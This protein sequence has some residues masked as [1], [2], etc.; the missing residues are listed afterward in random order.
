M[1]AIDNETLTEFIASIIISAS[2]KLSI[3]PVDIDGLGVRNIHTY[4]AEIAETIKSAGCNAEA[5]VAIFQIVM[6]QHGRTRLI[7]GLKVRREIIKSEPGLSA[8][9]FFEKHTCATTDEHKTGRVCTLKMD[10]SFPDICSVIFV[11]GMSSDPAESIYERLVVKL[12]FASINMAPEVQKVN[13]DATRAAWDSWG[14]TSGKKMSLDGS[15]IGFDEEIYESQRSDRIPLM[16]TGAN[17]AATSGS[18]GY[19]K[20]DIIAWINGLKSTSTVV[21]AAKVSTG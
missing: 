8:Y 3:N 17:V 19:S 9:T 10:M 14:K 18:M 1:V 7:D 21:P 15:V 12:W 5:R 20:K 16:T 11:A 6:A 13:E 4:R 2:N